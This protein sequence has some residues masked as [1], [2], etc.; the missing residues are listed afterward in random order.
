MVLG[1]VDCLDAWWLHVDDSVV[2][3]QKGWCTAAVARTQ[4]SHKAQARPLCTAC[5]RGRGTAPVWLEG[6]RE[7]E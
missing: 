6:Q 2:L 5:A 4:H 3:G 7:E 1:W